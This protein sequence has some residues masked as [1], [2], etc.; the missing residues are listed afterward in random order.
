[1]EID[2]QSFEIKSSGDFIR[3]KVISFAHPEAEGYDRSWLRSSVD[4][5]AGAFAGGYIADFQT[6]DFELLNRDLKRLSL[7]L[8]G[9]ASF[10][11]LES[12][13][14]FDILGD[15]LGHFEIQCMAREYA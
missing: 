9:Q 8:K 12:Q 11:P 5:N 15:G 13:L 14:E 6:S 7:A 3:I 4:I 2:D 1:M 10:R